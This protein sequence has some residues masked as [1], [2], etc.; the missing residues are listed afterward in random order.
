MHHLCSCYLGV[1]M[2]VAITA[3]VDKVEKEKFADECNLMTYSGQELDDRFHFLIFAD[4]ESA[5]L[6]DTY[7]NVTVIPYS[8]PE[9]EYYST[10]RFARSLRF[11]NDNREQ[12]D[13]YDYVVKTDTDAL[14]TPKLNEFPFN[15]SIYVGLARYTSHKNNI[16]QL[17][18]VATKFGYPSYS[19]ISDMHSTVIGTKDTIVTLMERSD[20]LCREMY[21]YLDSPGEWHGEE[22]WRGYYGNNSGIC[23]M[24]ALE[25]I[26]SSD[27]YKENLIVSTKIDAGSSW[28]EPWQNIYHYHCYHHDDIYSKFQAKFGA[29]KDLT[30]QSGD[31]SAV[32]CMNKYIERRDLGKSNR[33]QFA[34]PEFTVFDLPE[35]YNGY[36]VRYEFPKKVE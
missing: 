29:Y 6:I 9:D 20:K 36:R 23:S 22:L 11:V 2:K 26:L 7:D 13:G 24:Y 5:P 34:K 25:I 12:F 15:E 1:A 21:Y 31:S 4:P 32:Y 35:D 28:E 8:L 14:F 16:D 10:Y 17:K 27:G 33:S 3:Y 19:K 30:K 18:E